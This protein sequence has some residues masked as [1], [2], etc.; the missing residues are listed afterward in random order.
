MA[1]S[2][3]TSFI[4]GESATSEIATKI[5][6]LPEIGETIVTFDKSGDIYQRGI[7]VGKTVGYNILRVRIPLSA[8]ILTL[9]Q[10]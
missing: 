4:L 10:F 3:E 9:S 6:S 1:H 2:A 7:D 5:A 8:S